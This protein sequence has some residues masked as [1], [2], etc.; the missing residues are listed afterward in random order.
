MG[1]FKVPGGTTVPDLLRVRRLQDADVPGNVS[2]VTYDAY[3]AIRYTTA[4]AVGTGTS[5]TPGRPGP[6][7]T[8]APRT[9]SR[10]P[11]SCINTAPHR[12]ARLTD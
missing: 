8:T 3:T 11:L 6:Y 2:G 9:R 12:T 1:V 10:A 4:G 7:G 5:G